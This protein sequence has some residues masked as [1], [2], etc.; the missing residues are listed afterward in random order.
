MH[1]G[2]PSQAKIGKSASRKGAFQ[3]EMCEKVGAR[4]LCHLPPKSV[5]YHTLKQ[6][7]NRQIAGM[8]R[9]D[10][11][12]TESKLHKRYRRGS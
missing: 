7:M 10:L 12:H 9:R 8:P 6:G 2:A 4:A 3:I 11:K 5:K 1:S